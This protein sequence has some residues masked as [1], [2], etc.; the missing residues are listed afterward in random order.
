MESSSSHLLN[1][2]LTFIFGILNTFIIARLISP[3]DWGLLLITLS[4]VYFAIFFS[5]LFPPESQELIKYYIPH[6]TQELNYSFREVKKF[7][8]QVYM[9]R[10]ICSIGIL[11]IYLIIMSLL[12][13]NLRLFQIIFIMAPIIIFY[14]LIE[15]NYSVL[16]ALLK[17]K[18]ANLILF[19]NPLIS[20]I[21]IPQPALL[22]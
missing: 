11:V 6:L 16:L 5:K 10:F 3:A 21:K 15:L 7:L 8:S 14:I 9:I 17:F 12:N 13:F 4:F 19:I 2:Y 22:M 1:V 20:L 18:F